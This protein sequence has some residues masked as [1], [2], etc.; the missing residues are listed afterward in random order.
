MN[1]IDI[2]N[3]WSGVEENLKAIV[4]KVKVLEVEIYVVVFISVMFISKSRLT[5]C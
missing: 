5:F 1:P 2:K 4:K 3:V